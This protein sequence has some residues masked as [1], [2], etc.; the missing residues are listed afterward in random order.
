MKDSLLFGLKM[1][2]LSLFRESLLFY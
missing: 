1:F 2:S